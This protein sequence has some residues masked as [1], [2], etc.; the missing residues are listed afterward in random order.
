M[1]QFLKVSPTVYLAEKISVCI[2]SKKIRV[3]IVPLS[4]FRKAK[5]KDSQVVNSL[6]LHVLLL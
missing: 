3:L 6:M 4:K 2:D 1:L 5:E